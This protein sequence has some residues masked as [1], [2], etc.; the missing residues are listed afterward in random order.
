[1][2]REKPDEARSDL[3]DLLNLEFET[4]ASSA[5]YATATE[6]SVQLRHH[7]FDILYHATALHI[8]GAVYVTA[9]RRYYDRAQALG[10][11]ALL[12]EFELPH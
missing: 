10:Q 3:N 2:A 9:D 1:M 8:P 4:V 6:L 11:I 7:F 5:I 12:A